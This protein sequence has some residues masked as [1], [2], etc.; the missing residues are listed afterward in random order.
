MFE[1]AIDLLAV[2]VFVGSTMLIVRGIK[3]AVS[4]RGQGKIRQIFC[5]HKGP[6]TPTY[7]NGSTC[8]ACGKHSW[9][10]RE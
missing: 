9:D 10:S 8:N 6:W 7:R 1:A 2:C 3:F 4:D 5:R